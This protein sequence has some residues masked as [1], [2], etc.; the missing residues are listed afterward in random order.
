[1]PCQLAAP[2]IDKP[3]DGN[4]GIHLLFTQ[5]YALISFLVTERNL[6]S[7]SIGVWKA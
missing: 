7:G 2:I 5:K 3:E 4:R 6:M 1:M